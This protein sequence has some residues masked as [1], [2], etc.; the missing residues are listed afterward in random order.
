MWYR[1]RH[2]FDYV[3]RTFFL[4]LILILILPFVSPWF[5][6]FFYLSFTLPFFRSPPLQLSNYYPRS[7]RT[8]K[9]SWITITLNFTWLF[10]QQH[11]D[12]DQCGQALYFMTLGSF[13]QSISFLPF[14]LIRLLVTMCLMANENAWFSFVFTVFPP[15][16]FCPSRNL[17]QY[18][19]VVW[20]NFRLGSHW[21]IFPSIIKRPCVC[22]VLSKGEFR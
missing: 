3:P 7:C 18:S 8:E 5:F 17:S 20:I 15:A 1:H 21:G 11:G 10:W 2:C 22:C 14:P 16:I 4:L 12:C 9:H 6:P 19:H 13:F